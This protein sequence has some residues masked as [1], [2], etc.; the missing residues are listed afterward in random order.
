MD[1]EDS[2]I[3]KS[4]SEYNFEL[5]NGTSDDIETQSVD[6]WPDISF[7]LISGGSLLASIISLVGITIGIGF[8]S[9]PYTYLLS[10]LGIGNIIIVICA[11]ISYSSFY[12]IGRICNEYEITHY[13]DLGC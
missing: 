4:S 3:I 12:W 7:S 6:S 1:K 2:N 8:L 5:E 9:F 10:G 13:F 11:I